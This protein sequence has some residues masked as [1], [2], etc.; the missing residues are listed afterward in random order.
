MTFLKRLQFYLKRK[1]IPY[2]YLFTKAP[3]PEKWVF[4][5]GC[6]NS[7]TT[8]LHDVLGMHP[9]IGTM[10]DEGQF[11][12][13]VFP[14]GRQFGLPRLWALKPELFHLTENNGESFSASK[15]IRQWA[16]F[17]NHPDRKILLE[18]TILNS[19]RMRWLQKNIPNSYFIGVVRNGYA[20]AEGIRRKE[21][22]SIDKAITQWN[23]SNEIMLHDLNYLHHKML[24]RYEDFT[25]DPEKTVAEI[26]NF[27]GIQP[28]DPKLLSKKFT[29]HKLTSTIE[30]RNKKSTE[31]ITPEEKKIINAIAGEQLKKFGYF[32]D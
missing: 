31:K 29:V 5:V 10:P 16:F 18:K 22:H 30:D 8:L 2:G 14:T 12:S 19:A 3:H 9:D 26:C 15:L 25:A 27:L 4:I 6:Y 24:V 7:G 20:V 28:L 23:V 13:N 21:H 32:M 17:Y 11:Y 1:L